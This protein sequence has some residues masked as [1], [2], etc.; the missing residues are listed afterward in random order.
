MLIL[1]WAAV[2]V[3]ADDGLAKENRE[4]LGRWAR[5]LDRYGEDPADQL[6][7][8][9]FGGHLAHNVNLAAKE[10]LAIRCYAELHG[11]DAE[12]AEVWRARAESV[13]ESWLARA[14]N[15]DGATSLTFGGGGWSMKY[16]MVWDKVFAFGL[17]PPDFFRKETESYLP[18]AE[19]YGLPLDSRAEFTKSDWL[20]WCAA[21]AEGD[22]RRK[23]LA[24]IVRFLRCSH[25]RVPFSDWYSTNNCDSVG[26]KARSVQ[27]GVFMPILADYAGGEYGGRMR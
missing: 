1:L 17:T 3:G 25:A 8:D 11:G 24:P 14:Y 26:F 4:K 21:M 20:C 2:Y 16:N 22:T 19:E 13:A 10:P 7:T 23:L 12:G 27:G 15:A 18:H 6:C 5:Y 9:D